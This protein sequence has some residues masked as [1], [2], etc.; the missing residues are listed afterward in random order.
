MSKPAPI[1]TPKEIPQK[2]IEKEAAR[3]LVK[4]VPD[5]SKHWDH[6]GAENLVSMK[7]D[8]RAA[9]ILSKMRKGG[10]SRG[11]R[12]PSSP[13]R[14]GRRSSSASKRRYTRRRRA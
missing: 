2:L 9:D 4:E 8:S 1:R 5:R 7:R 12:L 3:I 6:T 10:L 11:H 14:K 13:T